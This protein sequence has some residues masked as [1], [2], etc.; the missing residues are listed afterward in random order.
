[1]S[2]VKAGRSGPKARKPKG[3][4]T[5]T[6]P[7]SEGSMQPVDYIGEQPLTEAERRLVEEAYARL[8][9]W[10]QENRV[11][12]LRAA[13]GRKVFRLQDPNQDPP[14]TPEMMRTLQLQT[15]KSTI[16]NCV[17]DQMDNLPEALMVPQ[18][19]DL[20]D[21][22]AEM[23][24][25]VRFVL[26]Q[27]GYKQ[28]HRRKVEDFFCAGTAVTQVVWDA[29][30]DGGKGN[31]GVYRYPIES[32]VWD[33]MAEDIQDARAVIKISWHPLSWYAEHYPEASAYIGDESNSYN[34]VGV[35]DSLLGFEDQQEGKAMLMEYW[36]R[37][38]KGG[39]YTINVA[40]IA[41]KALLER[42]EDV[43]AHG[44]YPFVFDAFTPVDGQPVGEGMVF[45]LTP[46]M[47]Y[48]NRYAHYIDE[49]LRYATKARMLVR[50]GAGIDQQQLAD[51]RQNIVEGN[52]IDEESVRWFETKPF[53]GMATQQMLQFQNDMKMDSGQ[54]Q[55]SRGEVS[56][57]V[58]A[59]SA[60]SALQEA[61]GKITRLRTAALS[62]GF[63]KIVEMILWLIA[64]FYDDER[65]ALISG[66]DLKTR[67]LHLS[68][69]HLMGKARKKGGFE[70]PP[71]TVE[72]Q[73][74]RSNPM[75]IQAQNDLMIQAYSMAAQAGQQ[76]PLSVLF[77]LLNVDGKEQILPELDR[78]DAQAQQM[79]AMA[80]QMQQL[81]AE[82]QN[83]KTSLDSYAQQMSRGVG[84]VQSAAFGSAPNPNGNTQM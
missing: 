31:V 13:E 58:T 43:Y 35:P 47:R 54:N 73:I 36:Y 69:E 44:M 28:Y 23:T 32:M 72:V 82:N 22:A 67:Q 17:A 55:F 61:G 78:L 21:I 75:R 40:Y 70:P 27:N 29:T 33:P 19:V 63:K 80:Q 37:R 60:I 68:A 71:Y 20:Q 39:R 6:R 42:Y 8:E 65:E 3:K 57:G 76:F 15:L 26:D 56:G 25:V 49:N 24:D 46:M 11:Y 74:Q 4:E 83:L 10:E 48:I 59:A 41:G 64:E 9:T 77:R 1:M 18:R 53:N 79:Q 2:E 7:A 12:H 52:T 62:S 66:P 5:P 34:S 50:K 45:E 38:Y 16:N 30:M 84:D 81:Q 51:W 14:N